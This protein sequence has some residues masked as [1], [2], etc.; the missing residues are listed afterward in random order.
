MLT[1]RQKEAARL[2]FEFGDE[3]VAHRLGIAQETLQA[4][5]QDPEFAETLHN[6][7]VENRRSAARIISRL[8][9]ESAREL[10]ALLRSDDDKN[11][12]KA[13]IEVLKFG[14]LFKDAE[15]KEGDPISGL[16]ERLAEEDEQADSQAMGSTS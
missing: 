5:M 10:G 8:Y 15:E 16:M 12:P 14:G 6:Q 9:L 2:L 3:E 7:I 13:I 4:W 1:D 11:K